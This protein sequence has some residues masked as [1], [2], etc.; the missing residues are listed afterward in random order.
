MVKTIPSIKVYIIWVAC[1]IWRNRCSFSVTDKVKEL[2]QRWYWPYSWCTN[3]TCVAIEFSPGMYSY[4]L[5]QEKT[6]HWLRLK[7]ITVFWAFPSVHI[8]ALILVY[9]QVESI[10]NNIQHIPVLL[11]FAKEQLF[12]IDVP[13]TNDRIRNGRQCTISAKSL[14]ILTCM[15][16]SNRCAYLDGHSSGHR[17]LANDMGESTCSILRVSVN[18]TLVG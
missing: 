15:S 14:L 5:N 9:L 6:L 11:Q 2:S 10:S 12:D 4:R 7:V 13:E 18:D 16:R 1:R 8:I 17:V 3:I